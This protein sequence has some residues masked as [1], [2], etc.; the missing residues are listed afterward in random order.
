MSTPAGGVGSSSLQESRRLFFLSF[1]FF[2]AGWRSNFFVF[3]LFFD[4][5]SDILGTCVCLVYDRLNDM[6]HVPK[7]SFNHSANTLDSE[8]QLYQ[9]CL[10]ACR[11]F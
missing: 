5:S 9:P 6:R 11:R 4:D 7:I 2:S 3:L 10:E 8:L 1:F